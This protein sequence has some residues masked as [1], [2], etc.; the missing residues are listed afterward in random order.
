MT[1][2]D[3]IV[4]TFCVVNGWSWWRGRKEFQNQTSKYTFLL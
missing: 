4:L 2:T 3:S 1:Y